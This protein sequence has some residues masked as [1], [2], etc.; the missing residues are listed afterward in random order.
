MAVRDKIFIPNEYYFI[1][2][3]I[4]GWKKVFTDD[5]YFQLVYKWFDYCRANYDNKI[6]AYV[7][8]PNHLH[9][10]TKITKKSPVLPKL[11]QNA[12]RFLAYGIVDLLKQDNNKELLDYFAA[13]ADARKEV[14][15]KIFEPRYDSLIIQSHKLFLEKFNYICKN[16]CQEKWQLATAPERYRHSSAA[17]YTF[18]QGE[19][20]VDLIDF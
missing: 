12:K 18:G 1:T 17:N 4:L 11:I 15:Y 10:I 20:D 13:N 7:I 2:F 8:M 19:Y 14:N 5:K 6:G 9:L 3:T 16:P